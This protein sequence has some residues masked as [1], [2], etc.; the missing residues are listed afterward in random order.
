MTKTQQTLIER[1]KA[2]SHGIAAIRRGY[3]T[4]RKNSRYGSR[5]TAALHALIAAGKVE[6]I[7]RDSHVVRI[8]GHTADHYSEVFYKL[9]GS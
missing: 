6:V 3:V 8:T 9:A 7:R 1:A 4:G 2:A 5:E